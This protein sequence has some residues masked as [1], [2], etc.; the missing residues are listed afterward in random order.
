[1]ASV[2]EALN[3]A[4]LQFQIEHAGVPE[5]KIGI[6]SNTGQRLF[7]AD[8]N[9]FGSVIHSEVEDYALDDDE[10]AATVRSASRDFLLL[11]KAEAFL[12]RRSVKARDAY[13]INLLLEEGASLNEN[14]QNHL[15]DTLS[16][17][18]IG[19]EE[20][21]SRIGQLT[22]KLFRLELKTLLPETLYEPLE[23]VDFKPLIEAVHS[24]YKPWL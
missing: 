13:D 8:F 16:S 19:T 3:F 12:L 17:Y 1:M 21:E 22:E 15:S 10:S 18:E 2:A 14:L 24:I 23:A 9:Q 4:P 6:N 7:R 11:Q 5:L 20:I